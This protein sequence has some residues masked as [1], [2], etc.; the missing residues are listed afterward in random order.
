MKT[1][2]N[3]FNTTLIIKTVFQTLFL[4]FEMLE[5]S[6]FKHY[7]SKTFTNYS[8]HRF[9]LTYLFVKNNTMYR[10]F[11]INLLDKHINNKL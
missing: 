10:L 4:T 7:L 3:N 1:I 5:Q 8:K 9:K 2:Y 11:Q 6:D